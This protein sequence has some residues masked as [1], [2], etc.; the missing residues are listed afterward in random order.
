MADIFD[1]VASDKPTG[2]IF[3]EVK[4]GGMTMREAVPA[5]TF[6]KTAPPKWFEV[7]SETAEQAAIAIPSAGGPLTRAAFGGVALSGVR[8]L[9]RAVAIEAGIH[10]PISMG[11][12]AIRTGKDFLAGSTFQM[13]GEVAGKVAGTVIQ[14][15][16]GLTGGAKLAEK[17]IPVAEANQVA[18]NRIKLFHKFGLKPTPAQIYPGSKSLGIL[19]GVLGYKPFS[20]DVML[21]K[22]LG[23]V[24]TL[25]EVRDQLIAKGGEDVS[26]EQLGRRIKQEADAIFIRYAEKKGARLN[27]LTDK[28]LS[29][30]GTMGQHEAGST[31]QVAMNEAKDQAELG[32]RN[33]YAAV[34]TKLPSGE[35]SFV[36]HPETIAAAQDMIAK[37]QESLLPTQRTIKTMQKIGGQTIPK[38]AS[39]T[40]GGK[41]V[42]VPLDEEMLGLLGAAQDRQA[43]WAGLKDTKTKLNERI[44]AIRKATGGKDTTESMRLARV[45]G[46]ID[47]DMEQYA[48]SEGGEDLWKTYQGARAQSKRYHDLYEKDVLGLMNQN[49]EDIVK[50][51]VKN[52]EVTLIRQV[53]TVAGE[54][55]LVPL[56][57]ATF[58]GI[59]DAATSGGQINPKVINDIVTRRMGG[60]EGE[61][62]KSLMTPEQIS[63]LKNIVDKGTFFN[64]KVGG[65]VSP[66]KTVDFLRA[67][68]DKDSGK[69]MNFIFQPHGA[70]VIPVAQKLLSK[71]SMGEVKSYAV[72]KVLRLGAQ[73]KYL[74]ATSSKEFAQ[75]DSAMKLLFKDEPWRYQRLKETITI[76]NWLD[77]VEKLAVNSSQ[78]SQV[79]MGSSMM[80]NIVDSL[81]T[82]NVGALV[83]TAAVPWAMARIYASGRLSDMMVRAIKLGPQSSGGVTLFTKMIMLMGNQAREREQHEVGFEERGQGEHPIMTQ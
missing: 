76:G 11:E 29:K 14:V 80:R 55:G 69:V 61:T 20:G 42:T 31:W 48:L 83:S 27:T 82:A 56:R 50:R 18:L 37:E 34:E 79:L 43:T 45:A 2:D 58:G 28:F 47:K 53:Q 3:D 23:T 36:P 10:E 41:E 60:F 52:G 74:P 24:D 63:A 21:R 73:G 12:A 44:A 72:D 39:I 51:I 77:R 4:S 66:M 54:K 25:M 22:S 81:K 26:V 35:K 19:E 13:G 71:E 15:G 1:T 57:Q 62:M 32:V 38:E 40:V 46:A 78:T 16:K 7:A 5:E 65:K 70:E 33:A 49:P 67:V 64:A 30:W 68:V 8:S 59:F 75:H 17:E 9:G 6:I